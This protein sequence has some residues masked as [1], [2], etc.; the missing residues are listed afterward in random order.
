MGVAILGKYSNF[1]LIAGLLMSTISL[2][3]TRRAILTPRIAI[4]LAVTLLVCLPTLYWNI[5]NPGEFMARSYKFGLASNGLMTRLVGIVRFLEATLNF[6]G[7]PI[8]VS[9]LAILLARSAPSS[10]RLPPAIWEKLTVRT[11]AIGFGIIAALMIV[12][13]A[14]EFRDRWF[15]PVLLFLPV[16]VAMYADR[17]GERGAVV[18][19]V[20]ICTGA[21][22][23]LLV[24][25]FHLVLSGLWRNEWRQHRAH[26]TIANSTRT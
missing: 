9:A 26:L 22:L 13:G 16:A 12:S 25:P 23:A 10:E 21:V 5:A 11:I 1:I 4:S 2:S 14:T 20:L 7:V 6:A 18:Q 24:L 17:L 15:L 3:D 19:K 8:L